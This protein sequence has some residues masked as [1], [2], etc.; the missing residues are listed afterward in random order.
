MAKLR[1]GGTILSER[2]RRLS[3]HRGRS[4]G[5]QGLLAS[6]SLCWTSSLGG[7]IAAATLAAAAALLESAATC[8]LGKA[9][10]L[11]AA[12]SPL[13][14]APTTTDICTAA[15]KRGVAAAKGVWPQFAF[16]HCDLF[17][18]DR[19]RIC[20][21]G[22]IVSSSVCKLHKGAILNDSVSS[23]YYWEWGGLT[24]CRETSKYLSSP[25]FSSS[26]RS[27]LA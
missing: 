7:D 5:F 27:S 14:A 11:T 17:C 24:F 1:T 25:Y 15:S 8:V 20:Q 2:V 23:C 10:A 13:H 9:S 22:R 12:T 6:N 16:F 18:A 3:S 19:M 21:D 4:E 26:D